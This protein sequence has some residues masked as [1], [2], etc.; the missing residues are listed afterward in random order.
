MCVYVNAQRTHVKTILF[1]I[2][3]NIIIDDERFQ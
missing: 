3:D 1:L 2:E